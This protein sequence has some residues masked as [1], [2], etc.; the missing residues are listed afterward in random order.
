MFKIK[1]FV[2]SNTANYNDQFAF[3]TVDDIF[4]RIVARKDFSAEIA[5]Q[6]NI[7][8]NL[9]DSMGHLIQNSSNNLVQV[10]LKDAPLSG[11]KGTSSIACLK[12][13]YFC[14]NWIEMI[15]LKEFTP[16]VSI[17][18]GN[19]SSNFSRVLICGGRKTA[20]QQRIMASDKLLPE[21]YLESDNLYSFMSSPIVNP[22][23]VSNSTFEPKH[24]EVDV[25]IC[26]KSN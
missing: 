16:S 22:A 18:A 19:V 25:I 15:F 11:S 17:K 2:R 7:N 1:H 26:L 12:G 24:P 13:S 10:S 9:I 5:N 4:N 14:Q 8:V 21:N 23:F 3:I 20:N 6:A